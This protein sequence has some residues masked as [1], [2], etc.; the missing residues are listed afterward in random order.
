MTHSAQHF[1]ALQYLD[2]ISHKFTIWAKFHTN[3]LFRSNITDHFIHSK[4]AN[5]SPGAIDPAVAARFYFHA[6]VVFRCVLRTAQKTDITS[7]NLFLFFY[8]LFHF[9]IL[10]CR[11]L[12]GSQMIDLSINILDSPYSRA[13]TAH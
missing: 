5:F 10:K 3:Y 9:S 2:Q 4:R 1:T 7:L 11:Q 6:T 12:R 8:N 13:P